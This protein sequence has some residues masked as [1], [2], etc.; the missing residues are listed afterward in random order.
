ML[1]RMTQY[2]LS[3]SILVVGF[4][5]LPASVKAQD[6]QFSQFYAASMYLNPAFTGNTTQHRASMIYRNQWSAI[7]GAFVSSAFSFDH[8]LA[9]LNSGV[10]LMVVH[11]KAGSGGLRYNSI[12]GLYSYAVKLS[13][14]V[15]A[16]AGIKMASVFRNY[17]QSKLVF[18]DQI[19]RENAT[20]SI[21]TDLDQGVSYMDVS[22]GGLV[23]T[24]YYWGGF[25]FDHINE[26]NQSLIGE[27]ANLPVKY[28][29][30]G[31]YKFLIEG[32]LENDDN[33]SITIAANYKAQLKWDQVDLGFYYTKK[34]IVLGLWYR[35][36]PGL[37]SYENNANNDALIL[38]VGLDLKGMKVGYSYDI[39]F[40]KLT[41]DTG[42]SHEI[43]LSYE[44]PRKKKKRRR[45]RFFVPCAKF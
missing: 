42:G 21:E 8:N 33:T 20:S 29:V 17:D 15:N 45:R 40:S 27:E 1:K 12:G 44:W 34:E 23:Y 18:A 36:I 5:V 41:G 2:L 7:P 38:L 11:D 9:N 14:K 24:D 43:S 31:G 13:K 35:G 26:P 4:F 19:I 28:S 32:G 10:G 37:K 6:P 25:S 30:H 22:V 39:T 3:L 16:R